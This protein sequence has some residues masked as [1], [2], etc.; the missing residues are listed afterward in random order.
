MIK[1][2]ISTHIPISRPL[3]EFYFVCF[4]FYE[5]LVFCIM[6]I[7]QC[8]LSFL[9]GKYSVVEFFLKENDYNKVFL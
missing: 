5:K 1:N 8:I 9:L 3:N 2:L 6:V 4:V 7:I